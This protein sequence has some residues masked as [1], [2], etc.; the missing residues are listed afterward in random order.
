M[1]NK[2]VKNKSPIM[3]E[4]YKKNLVD[5]CTEDYAQCVLTAKKLQTIQMEETQIARISKIY[6]PYRSPDH[7]I[8][9][10]E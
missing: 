3:C 10:D 7:F 4:M 8:Q 1:A 6:S 9:T 5:V 2:N